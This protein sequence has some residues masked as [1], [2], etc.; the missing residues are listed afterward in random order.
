VC[1]PHCV[2][3]SPVLRANTLL[4]PTPAIIDTQQR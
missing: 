3:Y 1:S 2:Q 4:A